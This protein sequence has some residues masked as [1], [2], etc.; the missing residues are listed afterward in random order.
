MTTANNK[1]VDESP[2]ASLEKGFEKLFN[3]FESFIKHQT[4]SSILLLLATVIALL[5]ANSPYAESYSQIFK[6]PFGFVLGDASFEMSLQHWINDGLM[7]LFFFLLGMELKREILVGDINDADRFFPVAFA[8]AGGMLIPASIFFFLN[9][10]SPYADAWG[11]TMATDTAFAVGILAL[12][13]AR[14][15]SAT[16]AFLT[17]LAIIDDLGAILV[18]ATVYSDDISLYYLGLSAA[19]LTAL[20]L[21]NIV[22]IRRPGVYLLIGALLWAAMHSSGVHATVAGILVAMSIPA[23]PKKEPAWFARQASRLLDKFKRLERK[24]D[25][26]APLLGEPEQHEVIGEIQNI[27]ESASTPLR[28]WENRFEYPVAL[29]IMPLFAFANA[30]IPLQLDGVTELFSDNMALG[31]MLGLVFGKA[32]SIPLFTWL[33]LRLNLGSLPRGL[34]MQHVVGLGLLAGMGFTMSI[35]IAGLSFEGN[36]EAQATAKAAILL[37]S[38]IAGLAGYLWLRFVAKQES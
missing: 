36:E 38:F 14:I 20:V 35:F 18:I 11:I 29:F 1:P 10:D 3:P 32:L 16:F 5:V 8:A 33:A 7:A 17:A 9:F 6:S 24:R 15:P 27:S 37:A 22:G 23:R 34:S 19:L 30:G 13:R 25:D 2:A 31:I 12:L 4:T 26:D 21:C 28:R